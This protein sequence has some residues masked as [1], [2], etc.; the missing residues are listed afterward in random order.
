MVGDTGRAPRQ[1][2][3]QRRRR[4]PSSPACAAS[5]AGP[6]Q[7][8]RHLCGD[9]HT[10]KKESKKE[11]RPHFIHDEPHLDQV[12]VQHAYKGASPSE[13]IT[14]HSHDSVR[15]K[16][17]DGTCNYCQHDRVR[18]KCLYGMKRKIQRCGRPNS[19][20]YFHIT[21]KRAHQGI[22]RMDTR[23]LSFIQG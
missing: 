14:M 18:A 1:G 6:C 23:D 7:H 3:S 22:E 19:T 20:N 21:D 13:D 15:E 5:S 4:R 16:G 8:P 17:R 11:T 12:S 10:Q 2:L 9:T